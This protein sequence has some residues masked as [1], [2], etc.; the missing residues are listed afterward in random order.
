MINDTL[1]FSNTVVEK[2]NE[3]QAV[4]EQ[5]PFEQRLST[6]NEQLDLFRQLYYKIGQLLCKY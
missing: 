4:K 1:N 2:L 5:Q 6:A 3:L